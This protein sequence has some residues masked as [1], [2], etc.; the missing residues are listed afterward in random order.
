[1]RSLFDV[2]AREAA[3]RE[4]RV[5]RA[6]LLAAGI[7]APRIRRWIADGRL[8]R[9]HNGV[10]AIGRPAPSVRGDYMGAVLA[11]GFGA[12]L[13]HW[14]AAMLLCLIKFRRPPAP[15]VTVPTTAGRRRPGIVIHRVPELHPLDTMRV[16]PSL[17]LISVARTL[18]DLAPSLSV[19]LLTRA[20]RS[21]TATCSSAA[22]ATAESSHHCFMS[23]SD[24][25]PVTF[26]HEIPRAGPHV[27]GREG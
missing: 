17:Q 20:S 3:K 12:V 11:C 4:G 24:R 6:Q 1:M 8:H 23:K 22:K 2:A 5:T 15:E 18:L 10:Y 13:S 14:A 25:I 7:D 9:V 19:A 21:A 27:R 16:G 26:R